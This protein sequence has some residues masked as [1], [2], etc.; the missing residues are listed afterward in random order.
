[1][2]ADSGTLADSLA[3]TG[4]HAAGARQRP[5]GACGAPE[6][7]LPAAGCQHPAG[8]EHPKSHCR[9]RA[10]GDALPRLVGMSRCMCNSQEEQNLSGFSEV[11]QL[12]PAGDPVAH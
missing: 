2:P 10:N 11:L 9:A 6:H 3:G 7:P 5:R 12:W 8:K 4:T 1:M